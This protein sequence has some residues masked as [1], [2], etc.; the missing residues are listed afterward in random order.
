MQQ[1]PRVGTTVRVADRVRPKRYAGKIG[2]V[3][4]VSGE[5]VYVNLGLR[6][7]WFL[8]SELEAL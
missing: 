5:E 4:T 3:T 7:A 8:P 1:I 2:T 6:Q